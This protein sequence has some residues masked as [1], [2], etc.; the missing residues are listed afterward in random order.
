MDHKRSAQELE[1]P[2]LGATVVLPPH[3]ATT[4]AAEHCTLLYELADVQGRN[5]ITI[6]K[7]AR[8]GALILVQE[9]Q[10]RGQ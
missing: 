4:L 8:F 1:S 9:C 5:F 2:G 6:R 7:H 3:L 10:S